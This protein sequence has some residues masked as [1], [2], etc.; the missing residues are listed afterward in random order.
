[1]WLYYRL[2]T[3]HFDYK[4]NR[5]NMLAS[6]T[7]FT[8]KIHLLFFRWNWTLLKRTIA[9]DVHLPSGVLTISTNSQLPLL[10]KDIN[11]YVFFKFESQS[12]WNKQVCTVFFDY[13]Y[14]P[15]EKFQQGNTL[16]IP[17]KCGHYLAIKIILSWSCLALLNRVLTKGLTV[18]VTWRIHHYN[19]ETVSFLTLVRYIYRWSWRILRRF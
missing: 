17:Q 9:N 1:M 10:S 3:T 14:F 16:C 6:L 7:N 19:R 12:P 8:V 11:F 15:A 2:N 13:F 4:R 18:S 5:V